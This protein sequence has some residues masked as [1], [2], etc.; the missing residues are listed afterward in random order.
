VWGSL[1]KRMRGGNGGNNGV[2]TGCSH[3]FLRLWWEHF[4]GWTVNPSQSIPLSP[5]DSFP[6]QSP[7]DIADTGLGRSILAPK[8]NAKAISHDLGRRD[9]RPP[10][11]PRADRLLPRVRQI[12]GVLFFPG[13][14]RDLPPRLPGPESGDSLGPQLG[15]VPENPLQVNPVD[16]L[17]GREA[18][19]HLATGV[20]TG[21][22]P[23]RRGFGSGDFRRAVPP[24][25][26]SGVSDKER[27]ID[28]M[29][30]Q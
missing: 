29:R 18:I 2:S 30:S 11:Q 16:L 22:A 14:H 3:L 13:I 25:R 8:L 7:Q 10:T 9:F 17:W 12:P 20:R 5:P 27:A 23:S 28:L 6:A 24:L 19:S 4:W 21:P 15:P 1:K 26:I